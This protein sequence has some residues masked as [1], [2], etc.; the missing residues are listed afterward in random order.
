MVFGKCYLDRQPSWI[1]NRSTLDV[2]RNGGL[3]HLGA[4]VCAKYGKQRVQDRVAAC[5]RAFDG[6]RDVGLYADGLDPY[7]VAHI[8]KT[9][10]QPVLMYGVQ[11]VHL[12]RSQLSSM[13]SAQTSLVKTT[14]G[15]TKG[16]RSIQLLQAL[17]K[18]N[19]PSLL[20]CINS[21]GLLEAHMKSGAKGRKL[22]PFL[23][24]TK[25][26][27]SCNRVGRCQDFCQK[28]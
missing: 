4:T 5:R 26:D 8:W 12:N 21:L 20:Y 16:I 24:T 1:L 14:L 28:N 2:Q 22:Y 13:D 6:M 17:L 19:K 3:K 15:L 11:A 9:A 25:Q 23:L 7:T 27:K 18:I 10:L